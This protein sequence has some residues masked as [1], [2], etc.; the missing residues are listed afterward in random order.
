M[1][2][3]PHT[4]T[5]THT[6]TQVSTHLSA[7]KHTSPHLPA[8]SI[9]PWLRVQ[10]Y[11]SSQGSL[12]EIKKKKKRKSVI[13]TGFTFMKPVD[14]CSLHLPTGDCYTAENHCCNI[15]RIVLGLRL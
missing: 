9:T 1:R 2:L 10:S 4:H 3:H 7:P 15:T 13:L 14:L 12:T 11:S 5:H 8:L 6:H